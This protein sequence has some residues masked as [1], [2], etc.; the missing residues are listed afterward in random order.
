M[1]RYATL[2]L[3]T[4]ACGGGSGSTDHS[5]EPDAVDGARIYDDGGDRAWHDAATAA[6]AGAHDAAA[7][8]AA[9]SSDAS[10]AGTLLPVICQTNA[11][12]FTGCNG[13]DG[14]ATI[15]WSYTKWTGTCPAR[16]PGA[17]GYCEPGI[18]CHV[19]VDDADGGTATYQGK[20]WVAGTAC[21]NACALY[22]GQTGDGGFDPDAGYG[23]TETDNCCTTIGADCTACVPG[24]GC[25][26]HGTCEP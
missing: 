8:D 11:G 2:L 15:T 22:A 12:F 9:G 20:C 26:Y 19:S 14:P 17:I 4:T 16:T 25:D 24:S 21:K 10:D 3:L 6:D 7:V 13:A 23:I 1:N 5:A 18:P